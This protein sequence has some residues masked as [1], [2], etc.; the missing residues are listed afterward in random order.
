ML[1][2]T[3]PLLRH[4]NQSFGLH[5]AKRA[6]AITLTDNFSSEANLQAKPQSYSYS[7]DHHIHE[8]QKERQGNTFVHNQNA[9][10]GKARSRGP[11]EEH[12]ERHQWISIRQEND[13][14]KGAFEALFSLEARVRLFDPLLLRDQCNCKRCI[15]P[16]SQQKLFQSSDIPSNIRPY[17]IISNNNE[18]HVQWENDVAGYDKDHVTTITWDRIN[19]LFSDEPSRPPVTWDKALFEKHHQQFS[20][21]EARNNSK[22]LHGVLDALDKHGL[23]FLEDVP[24]LEADEGIS[25][26]YGVE[27]IGAEIGPLRDSLYGRTWDVRSVAN[28]KNIAY[29]HQY[30][31]LHMDLL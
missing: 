19:E 4:T 31:G 27:Q 1:H 29:T 21:P 13:S 7:I 3:N 18:A 2:I 15:D 26:T 30:L 14:M 23:V 12:I 20:W 11:Q 17:E 16:D 28:A 6:L 9:Q 5:K 24:Q 8:A 22:S 10:S 25:S